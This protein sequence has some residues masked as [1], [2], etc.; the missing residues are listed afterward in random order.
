MMRLGQIRLSAL[1]GLIH[2]QLLRPVV[3]LDWTI[4]VV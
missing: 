4:V 1:I 2:I 3:G